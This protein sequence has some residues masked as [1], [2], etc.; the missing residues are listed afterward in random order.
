MLNSLH[1]QNKSISSIFTHCCIKIATNHLQF[2]LSIF[3]NVHRT[4]TVSLLNLN[5]QLR[6]EPL[7]AQH[8]SGNDYW[9]TAA[10]NKNE[11]NSFWRKCVCLV[12]F[13][14]IFQSLILRLKQM[15]ALKCCFGCVISVITKRNKALMTDDRWI[16]PRLTTFKRCLPGCLTT[17]NGRR[18]IDKYCCRL[19]GIYLKSL[20]SVFRL[21]TI[22]MIMSH[23][24]A[25]TCT[26]ICYSHF[27]FV[28]P[29]WL[30]GTHDE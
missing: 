9:S 27:Y 4:E 18:S 12:G 3:F 15:K 19:S 25:R 13:L 22:L 10:P 30:L 14:Y 6:I 11:M 29:V 26:S 5:K 24:S 16:W 8:A 7:H 1:L 28:R 17:D 20:I 21:Q 23:C 2:F